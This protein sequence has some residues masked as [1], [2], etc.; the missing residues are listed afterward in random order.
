M[1]ALL[2]K[3][4]NAQKMYLVVAVV[5]VVAGIF[6]FLR[7]NKERDFK[8]LYT[9]VSA[10]D[11]GAVVAKLK[12]TGADYRV[13]E[14]GGTILVP[15]AKVAETRLQMAALG[16]PK[17]GRIGYELFDKT[18]FGATDFT[19]QVN[20]HRALEGELE[21]SVMSLSEVEKARVHITLPKASLFVENRQPAK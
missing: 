4:T 1:N 7:W 3:L 14:N 12:E 18:N 5:V 13:T 20:Y 10:E 6:G 8:P 11:A 19:E 2:A 21:R 17:T 15:S 9:G 16:L